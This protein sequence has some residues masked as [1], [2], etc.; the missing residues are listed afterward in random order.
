MSQPEKVKAIALISGGLDSSLSVAVCTKL[1]IEVV[2]LHF[3][4][5]F[6][7]GKRDAESF[8]RRSAQALGIELIER[9]S[10]NMLMAAV[11][12]PKFGFGKHLNPCMDC[13]EHMLS[14]AREMLDE[15]GARFIISGEVL[16]QR[17]MSQRGDAIK[18]I[19]RE[20]GVEG[21][22]LRPLCA[23]VMR[24]SLAE[25]EG[26]VDREKLL[27]IH[28]RSRRAQYELAEKL[29]VTVFSAP[30]GGCLLTDPGF[31]ARLDE[32]VE[33]TPDFDEN[34]VELL[35]FGRHFRLSPGAKAVVGRD[36][37]DNQCVED[38][39]RGADV[40]LEVTAGHTPVTLLRGDAGDEQLRAAAA[41]TARYAR[42]RD[43]AEVECEYWS[44][45]SG[46]ARGD[47]HLL[48]VAP[49]DEPAVNELAIG[50]VNE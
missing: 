32:L 14:R 17:P 27:G 22:V 36:E 9:S 47:G 19:D 13:R 45:A 35:K 1:G 16:G 50:R 25:Q 21:L 30:A 23:K 18:R 28:G 37:N 31:S 3:T 40:L 15:L 48:T 41:L 20:A 29:N 39:A 24:E 38:L 34:D 33:Q 46:G 5:I 2:G 4:N 11:R 26:W 43:Q 42:S 44:P 6:H 10:T 7:A 8:A 12:N 49:A